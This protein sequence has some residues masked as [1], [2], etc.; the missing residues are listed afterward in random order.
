MK[1]C[2]MLSAVVFSAVAFSVI[3]VAHAADGTINFTGTI[4]D[5]ACTVDAA[6]QT[7]TMGSVNKSAFTGAGT[8]SAPTKFSIVLKDCPSTVTSAQ[9]TFDGASDATNSNLLALT[10]GTDAAS[11]LGLALY[12]SDG[13]TVIPV[14]VA[15]KSI[16]LDT[17]ASN[18][19]T[20]S[21]IAKYMA[22]AATVMPGKADATTDFTVSYN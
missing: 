18:V 1:K 15:S 3:N 14:S 13:S 5:A 6:T 19:N 11:G 9:V 20:L 17:T 22:T 10:S 7:I 8:V 21:Y 16:T 4:L 2:T 12:E